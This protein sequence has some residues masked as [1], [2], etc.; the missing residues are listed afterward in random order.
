[1]VWFEI[2]SLLFWKC[3]N[4]VMEMNCYEDTKVFVEKYFGKFGYLFCRLC[5]SSSYIYYACILYWWVT[6]KQCPGPYAASWTITNT[7]CC[8]IWPAYMNPPQYILF[9]IYWQPLGKSCWK[10]YKSLHKYRVQDA[11]FK[12]NNL[13]W[14]LSCATLLDITS[15]APSTCSIY[16]YV[17]A[18]I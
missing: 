12:I 18:L 3:A 13:S 7:V 16:K 4:V 9:V 2:V 17:S 10:W 5:Q 8:S 14:S 11:L 1:M 15:H 6:P